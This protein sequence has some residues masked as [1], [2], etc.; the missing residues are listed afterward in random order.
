MVNP[1][2]SVSRAARKTHVERCSLAFFM[3]NEKYPAS[4]R[5]DYADIPEG[6][7]ICSLQTGE[8]RILERRELYQ[9]KGEYKNECP[10]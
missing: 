8:E 7:G 6:E 5:Q 3:I 2:G 9:C 1:S 10:L 4:V